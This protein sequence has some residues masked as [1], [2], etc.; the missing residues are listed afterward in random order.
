[1]RIVGPQTPGVLVLPFELLLAMLGGALWALVAAVLK[2]R[3]NVNEIFGG[4]ALNFTAQ[5]ILLYLLTGPWKVGN[6][7]QTAPFEDS[8]M[9]PFFT[10]GQSRSLPAVIIVVVAFLV[11]VVIL[12]GTHWGLQLKAMG[13]SEKSAFL[14]GVHT[15]RNVLLSMMACG[16]L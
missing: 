6:Y 14:L 5:N 10:K 1:A 11:V 15:N 12:R 4:V 13:R 8:A 3:G 7:P 9:F 2:T 16:A